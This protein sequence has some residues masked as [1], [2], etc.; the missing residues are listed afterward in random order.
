M[1]GKL[2]TIV[3]LLIVSATILGRASSQSAS[4][5]RATYQL[6]NPQDNNWDL[7]AEVPSAPPS[8]RINPSS[9]A[10]DTDGLPSAD[11]MA[12]KEQMLAENA[13]W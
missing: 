11:P 13:Y 5:V 1:A 4:N 7:L 12:L 3:L 6:Y 8:M 9:G 10:A 2:S